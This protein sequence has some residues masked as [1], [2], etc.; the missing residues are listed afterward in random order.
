MIVAWG[1]CLAIF[2]N[3][4]YFA[5]I[6][7]GVLTLALLASLASRGN[8]RLAWLIG[9]VGLAAA[10]PALLLGAMQAKFSLS[11]QMGWI[12]TTLREAIRFVIRIVKNAAAFNLVAE[13][14]AITAALFL[15]EDDKRRS[16]QRNVMVLIGLTALFFAVMIGLNAIVPMIRDR[17]LMS[18]A[19]AVTVAVALLAAGPGSR[20]Y[21]LRIEGDATLKR[22]GTQF[23]LI[24]K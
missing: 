11:G 13:A 8:W 16:Q 7:G 23:L 22:F 10:T 15:I 24:V 19:G 20:A 17:Y 1:A 3:L 9:L 5:T 21:N 12:T 18:A 6:F 14:C 4:H 2:V